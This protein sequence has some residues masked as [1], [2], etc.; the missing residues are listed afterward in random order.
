[1]DTQLVHDSP[2]HDTHNAIRTPTNPS[3]ATAP[4][5]GTTFPAAPPVKPVC[6]GKS[7]VAVAR[8]SLWLATAL[9]SY[10]V[11]ETVY[12]VEAWDQVMTVPLGGA[13]TVPATLCRVEV[14]FLGK[15][16]GL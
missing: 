14:P 1:M 3:A 13:V 7:S 12:V 4:P 9:A 2:H 16:P 11:A 15:S 5:A 6:S 10:P 8:Y